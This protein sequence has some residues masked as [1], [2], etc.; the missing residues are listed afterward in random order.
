MGIIETMSLSLHAKQIKRK[1]AGGAAQSDNF[2][3]ILLAHVVVV[4]IVHLLLS[5]EA[6][7]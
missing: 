2:I 1:T 3:S 4:V 5:K 7:Y 6:Q